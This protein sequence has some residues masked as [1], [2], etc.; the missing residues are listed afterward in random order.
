[1]MSWI[2]RK[3]SFSMMKSIII[4]ILGMT[5]VEK[6]ASYREARCNIICQ[7]QRHS[8]GILLFDMNLVIFAVLF[9]IER[10]KRQECE[11]FYNIG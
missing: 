6:L 4:C 11:V 8:Q 9:H 2:R 10:K 1:M 3:I 5:G 7:M